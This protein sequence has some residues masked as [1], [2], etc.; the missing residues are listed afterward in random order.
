M[1]NTYFGLIM[2][3]HFIT[4]SRLQCRAP[5]WFV[6][7]SNT[8]IGSIASF[9]NLTYQFYRSHCT[10]STS[11]LVAKLLPLRMSRGRIDEDDWYL[12]SAYCMPEIHLPHERAIKNLL[13]LRLVHLFSTLIACVPD[14]YRP[15]S[16]TKIMMSVVSDLALFVRNIWFKNFHIIDMISLLFFKH[17]SC[18]LWYDDETEKSDGKVLS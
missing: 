5:L 13:K 14:V 15:A 3:I 8:I 11:Y 12:L 4:R 6:S 10:R 7:A 16:S 17:K 2:L 18:L 1:L 9:A